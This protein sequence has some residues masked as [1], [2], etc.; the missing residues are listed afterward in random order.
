MLFSSYERTWNS[1]LPVVLFHN[2]IQTKGLLYCMQCLMST[3]VLTIQIEF[4]TKRESYYMIP[5]HLS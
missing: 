2:K 4:G 3:I 5:V 1:T